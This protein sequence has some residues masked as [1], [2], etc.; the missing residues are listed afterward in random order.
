MEQLLNND[1]LF[2]SHLQILK[3]SEVFTISQDHSSS[4]LMPL[5]VPQVNPHPSRA[6]QGLM[7]FA[8]NFGVLALLQ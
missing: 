6:S 1:T 5:L 7:N 4:Q 3:Y 2:S 8:L